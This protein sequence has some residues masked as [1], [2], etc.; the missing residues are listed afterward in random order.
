MIVN[1]L[2]VYLVVGMIVLSTNIQM[3][4]YEINK[5]ENELINQSDRFKNKCSNLKN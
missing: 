2:K 1:F 5:L 3:T 4:L